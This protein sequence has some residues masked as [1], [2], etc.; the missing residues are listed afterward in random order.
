ME[1]RTNRRQ[2]LKSLGAGAG[3]IAMWGVTSLGQTPRKPNFVI[4][5]CDDMGYGDLG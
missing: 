4:I 5:F 3:A 1:I 2:F